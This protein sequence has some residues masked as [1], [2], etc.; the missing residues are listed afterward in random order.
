MSDTL[1][2]LPKLTVTYTTDAGDSFSVCLYGVG[3]VKDFDAWYKAKGDNIRAAFKNLFGA[4]AHRDRAFFVSP[5][6]AN[7]LDQAIRKSKQ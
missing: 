6:V 7:K 4:I 2:G 3:P 1:P 5:E